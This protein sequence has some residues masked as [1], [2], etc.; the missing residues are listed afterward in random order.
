MFLWRN[1]LF[2]IHF[3]EYNII[4]LYNTYTYRYFMDVYWIVCLN[5]LFIEGFYS[6]FYFMF[7]SS[8]LSSLFFLL[9][10]RSILFD[11]PACVV[12]CCMCMLCVLSLCLWVTLTLNFPWGSIKLLS[13]YILSIHLSVW[14]STYGEHL[15]SRG[16]KFILVIVVVWG[17]SHRWCCTERPLGG[18]VTLNND[19]GWVFF[20]LFRVLTRETF[21]ENASSI[22][23]RSSGPAVF[24]FPCIAYMTHVRRCV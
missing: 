8:I 3:Y 18:G 17:F 10:G 22:K 12:L 13:I 14:F 7:L 6:F 4:I 5:S 9:L 20:G 11:I 21:P 2:R 16:M 19:L 24:V 1:N 15:W 23:E